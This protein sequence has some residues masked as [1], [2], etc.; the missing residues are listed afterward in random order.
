Y[1]NKDISIMDEP[2]TFIDSKSKSEM[3][4][5]IIDFLG[6]DKILIYITRSSEDLKKFD[7]VFYFENGKLLETGHL[8]ELMCKKG[9]TYKKIKGEKKK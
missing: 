1:R 6:E 3:I 8:K 2:F 4:E 5:D 9:K 7:R